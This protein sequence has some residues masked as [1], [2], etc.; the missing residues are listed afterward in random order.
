MIRTQIQ[1]PD[2]LY[3]ELKALA[4]EKEWSLA[5][6]LRR[7]GEYVLSLYPALKKKKFKGLPQPL[8][9]GR[10]RL[11]QAQWREE[12]HQRSWQADLKK[13]FSK[14]SSKS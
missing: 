2:K 1:I 8:S 9:L 5:E 3:H 14:K 6:I 11:D 4:E 10:P 7:G 13:E 12:I